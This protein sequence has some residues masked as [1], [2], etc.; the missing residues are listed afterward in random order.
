MMAKRLEDRVTLEGVINSPYVNVYLA[1]V[2]VLSGPA[3][4]GKGEADEC[5]EKAERSS[6]PNVKREFYKDAVNTY[7]KLGARDE[8]VARAYCGMGEVWSDKREERLIS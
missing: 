8:A 5:L 6:D 3:K 7:I 4:E 1:S 2:L